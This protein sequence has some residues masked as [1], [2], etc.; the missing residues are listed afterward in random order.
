MFNLSNTWLLYCTKDVHKKPE[1][2]NGIFCELETR[3]IVSTRKMSADTEFTPKTST[4]AVLHL[5]L[6]DRPSARAA[7]H[8]I[9]SSPDQQSGQSPTHTHTRQVLYWAVGC[10]LHSNLSHNRRLAGRGLGRTDFFV[11]SCVLH[12]IVNCFKK[13]SLSCV[14]VGRH[15][16]TFWILSSNKEFSGSW[17]CWTAVHRCD[18]LN[19]KRDTSYASGWSRR[20]T[21]VYSRQKTSKTDL[22]T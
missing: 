19:I 20:P 17:C 4:L 14:C 10:V 1:S 9:D 2:R 16:I 13:L 3:P 18:L 5:D 8:P 11:V 7:I 15:S 12:R 21:A 22:K 6:L